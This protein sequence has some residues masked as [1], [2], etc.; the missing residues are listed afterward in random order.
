M[1]SPFRWPGL[2]LRGMEA[3]TSTTSFRPLSLKRQLPS[4]DHYLSSRC[5]ARLSRHRSACG[6]ANQEGNCR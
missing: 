2:R 5:H 6:V 3:G 1:S 4:V